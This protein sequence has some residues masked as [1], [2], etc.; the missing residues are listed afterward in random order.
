[1]S[2]P[3]V[4]DATFDTEVYQSDLPVLVEFGTEWCAPCK[5]IEP[6]LVALEDE[7]KDKV[8]V[9]KADVEN[10]PNVAMSLGVRGIPALFVFHDG[11]LKANR[12]GAASKRVLQDWVEASIASETGKT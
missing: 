6:S 11:Q 3:T 7:L 1:M 9:F 12:T 2:L 4:T 8:R 10:A 5:Q